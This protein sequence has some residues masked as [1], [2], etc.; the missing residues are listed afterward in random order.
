MGEA[1]IK[2]LGV[3][4]GGGNAVDL[5]L[6]EGIRGVELVAINTDAQ[7][8]SNIH[9]HATLRIGENLT[10]GLGAGGNPDIGKQ[11][12]D[13]SEA[14]LEDLLE[15][16]DM[17]FIA[18]GMGGGTGTGAAPKIAKIAHGLGILTLGIVTRPF[19]FEGTAREQRAERGIAEL[20]NHVDSLIEVPNHRLIQIAPKGT[21]LSRAFEIANQVLS[22]GIRGISDLITQPGLINLDFADIDSALR[23]SKTALIGIGTATG[24][25]RAKE[26]A[27]E[28]INSSLLEYSITGA[29]HVL[30][31]IAGG[32]TISLDEVTEAA[33]VISEIVSVQTDVFFGT[34]IQNSS[35]GVQVTV[36]ASGFPKIQKDKAE[37]TILQERRKGVEI[38]SRDRDNL[39][40]PAFMRG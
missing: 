5:M 22:H 24:S 32:D 18:A 21:S 19:A 20:A 16:A 40:I 8:L 39:D 7:A 14:E 29:K 6:R 23:N 34:S 36:I 37:A 30:L 12:V 15:G 11:A 9:A 28:A 27:R 35:D 26:A 1:V 2:I 10:R 38:L 13:E 25:H 33:A 3:G 4:G 31:N 17:L